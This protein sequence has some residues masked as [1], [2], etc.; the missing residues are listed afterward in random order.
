MKIEYTK[1]ATDNINKLID[2]LY[3]KLYP[4]N[5]EKYLSKINR[6]FNIQIGHVLNPNK[7]LPQYGDYVIIASARRSKYAT[8]Y[9]YFYNIE[10]DG[11][12]TVNN[13]LTEFS[14]KYYQ[15]EYNKI[16]HA[17]ISGLPGTR[18]N[19]ILKTLLLAA[20]IYAL[21]KITSK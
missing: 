9:Y 10:L 20:G 7:Y 15:Q 12:I 18:N 11:A 2:F 4:E 19:N 1:T 6:N 5:A 8:K 13:F 14:L 17:S 3:S 16:R 21:Y